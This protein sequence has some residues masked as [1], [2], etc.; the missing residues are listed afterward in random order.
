[1]TNLLALPPALGVLGLIIAFV[2]YQMVLRQDAG[3][4][5][6]QARGWHPS[7]PARAHDRDLDA[8]PRWRGPEADRRR[9]HGEGIPCQTE[10]RYYT[11]E[12]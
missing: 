3:D 7:A 1:M 5:R 4:G 2:I 12:A 8:A 11:I 9:S 6:V 10:R